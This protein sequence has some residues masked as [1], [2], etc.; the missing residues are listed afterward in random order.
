MFTSCSFS[1]VFRP[2][3]V[4][5][6]IKNEKTKHQITFTVIL[7]ICFNNSRYIKKNIESQIKIYVV[8]EQFCKKKWVEGAGILRWPQ[9]I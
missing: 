9:P 1:C 7:F 8:G 5:I 2:H 3:V 6:L 4:D